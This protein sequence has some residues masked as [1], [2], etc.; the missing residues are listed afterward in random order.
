MKG[1]RCAVRTFRS[2]VALKPREGEETDYG[3]EGAPGQW[4]KMPVS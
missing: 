3:E 4:A 1:R 2:Q